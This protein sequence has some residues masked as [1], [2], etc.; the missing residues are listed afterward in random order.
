MSVEPES[1]ADRATLEKRLTTLGRE[2]PTFRWQVDPETGQTLISGMG[3]LHLEIKVNRLRNDFKVKVRV[4]KPRVS[5]RETLRSPITTVG[6]CVRQTGG[7]G[8]F[9]KL[10]VRFEPHKGEQSIT[11]VNELDYEKVPA[12]LVQAADLGV[13]GSLQSGL[14]GYPLMN[15]R[16]TILDAELDEQIS[17]ETALQAAG[18]D[19]VHQALRDNIVLLE[20]MMSLEV[21]VPEEYFGAVSSD[22]NVRRAQIEN[23]S[24]RGKLRVIEGLVPLAR[25]FDYA[26][27]IRSLTQG[28]GTFSMEPHSYE[29]APDDVLHALLHPEDSF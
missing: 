29:P 1:S 3:T 7:A 9:G 19:A 12:A 4:G 14:L 5:Y 18:A 2:D 23:V 24:L 27:K 26:E 6:E 17:N 15:V 13:R 28:R 25:M 11:V 20:P 10:K 22:L 21:Q 16:A 8:L